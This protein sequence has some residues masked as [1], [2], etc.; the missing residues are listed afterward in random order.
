MSLQH[1][2][3]DLQPVA[4]LITLVGVN[5]VFPLAATVFKQQKGLRG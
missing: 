5:C 1:L 2:I 3:V 4:A